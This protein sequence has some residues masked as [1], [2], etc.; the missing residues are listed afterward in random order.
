MEHEFR[1]KVAYV[2]SLVSMVIG[3]IYGS[4]SGY[5]GGAVDN[6]MMRIVD[7]LYGFPFLIVVILLQAILRLCHAPVVPLA[8]LIR[9]LVGMRRWGD[10]V[11]VYRYWLD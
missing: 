10:A 3:V 6:V 11:F 4:I 5:L 9:L 8:L 2:A 7:F 1:C